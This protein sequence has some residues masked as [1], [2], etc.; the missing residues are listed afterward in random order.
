M[1][2]L[3]KRQK[4]ALMEVSRRKKENE[5]ELVKM[6]ANMLEQLDREYEDKVA[7]LMKEKQGKTFYIT[8][9]V[10]VKVMTNLKKRAMT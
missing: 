3:K 4:A 10:K 6:E 7:A 8:E 5:E 1:K 9:K 2:S